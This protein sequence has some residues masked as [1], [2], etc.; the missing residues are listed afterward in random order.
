MICEILLRFLISVYIF[1]WKV[2][3]KKADNADF[4]DA[5]YVSD[6]TEIH[7]IDICRLLQISQ[8]W[9]IFEYV[10]ELTKPEKFISVNDFKSFLLILGL[11]LEKVFQ[12]QNSGYL[13]LLG[14]LFIKSATSNMMIAPRPAGKIT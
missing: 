7:R 13:R 11:K 3:D 4:Q 2:K 5:T 1:G 10:G 6:I 12:I 9:P 14:M 8:V